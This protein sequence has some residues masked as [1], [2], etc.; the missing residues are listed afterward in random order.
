MNKPY[1]APAAPASASDRGGSPLPG[2]APAAGAAVAPPHRL[3]VAAVVAGLGSD[4]ARGL[5]RAEAERRIAEYGENRL[6]SAPETPWWRRLAEQFQDFLVIIL[7]VATVISGLEWLLQEP[8][9]SALPYEAIV[10]MA[11]VLLN[12]LLG[13]VQEARAEKSVRALMALAA[14]ESTVV[15][16]GERQRIPAHDI[17]PGDV[18]LVEAGDRIPADARVIEDANLRTDEAALTG[19]SVPV[20]KDAAAIDH[21]VG[22]GDRRNMLYAGTTATYGRGRAIVV[23]TGMGTE[24]GKIA[25]LIEGAEKQATPLQKELDRTGKRLSIIML[26]ICGVVFATGL[27]KN[28]VTDLDAILGLFL[29]AVALAVAAIPEALPAIVTVGLSLGVRRMAQ[30]N[31]IVRKLPAVETLG[32][33]TVICSDKT[34]T[35]TR[36]EMTVRTVLAGDAVVD[37]SGSGY[38][39]EGEFTVAGEPLASRPD[40]QEAVVRTLQAAALVNDATLASREGRWLVQGDPTEGALVV[41]ARKAGLTE[42]ALAAMPRIAEIPF[43]SE[44]KRHATLHAD[45][46]RPGELTLCVKGAPEVLLPRCRE[47][48]DGRR[49]VALDDAGRAAVAERNDALAAQALRTL[50][51]ATRT[52]RAETLGLDPAAIAAGTT[53]DVE[54][55]E[56][57][58][59]DLVLVG[60][61][62]MIDPPRAEAKDAVATA[63]RA[64]IRTVM[65][66]G[67]HPATAEAIA[68]ELAIVEPGTRVVTGAELRRTSD[69]ELDRIVEAVRVFARVDPDHKLRIVEALQRRGHIVAMTGDG[70]ND[71]PALKTANIG[72]AMGITGTD[73]SKEAADMVLTDDNFASIV[74]AIEEGRGIFDNIRKYLIYLLSSN[75]GELLTMFAGVM[76]A[77][78]LGLASTSHGLFLPLLAAQLLWINL[79]TDGPPALA[80]GVDPKDADVMSRK[81][82]RRGA[83]VIGTADWVRIAGVG[84]VMMVGTLA[85][86]DAYYPGGMI[87]LFAREAAPNPAD[88]AYARTMAFT[89]L[90]MFQLFNVF[91]SRSGHRSAFVG[92]FDNLWLIGAVALSLLA[93]ILVIYAPFMQAAFQTVSLGLGDWLVATAV[94]ATLLVVMEIVKLVLRLRG[95]EEA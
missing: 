70:I 68:R 33:A 59:D 66:T 39:P 81:P 60:L 88:E 7:L 25:E 80:L 72:V 14:P 94:G 47:I 13:F 84:A 67:D 29:F 27:L 78:L 35:L 23:A 4:A 54:L 65:I 63:R 19:E 43:T 41:A 9:E 89:T 31:A 83:G 93:Q 12:A 26:V 64:H 20:V 71:A 42:A 36:N 11:I 16:D 56:D 52:I 34:G 82:R 86:L 2:S 92:L 45:R 49:S 18:L 30:S 5:T 77:G 10:I 3:P 51:V 55:P 44:R 1:P 57:I 28:P 40:V 38:V 73:V 37:V 61:V 15:R 8:R 74:K 21:D 90:M 75:A 85:V 48:F 32:A 50:A 62:G 76:F 6:K 79:I 46:A 87:T 53:G 69:A 95:V 22:L 58:E 91:N 24:V 17:V